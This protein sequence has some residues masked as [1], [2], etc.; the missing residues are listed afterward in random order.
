MMSDP[1]AEPHLKLSVYSVVAYLL[2]YIAAFI[3]HLVMRGIAK[4]ARNLDVLKSCDYSVFAWT[5]A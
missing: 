3:L 2:A 4:R 1:Q 5:G